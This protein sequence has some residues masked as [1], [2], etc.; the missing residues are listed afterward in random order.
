ME[1]NKVGISVKF[2][3][4]ATRSKVHASKT[5]ARHNICSNKSKDLIDLKM[6]ISNIKTS[7]SG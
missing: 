2:N 5:K 1:E 6:N 3:L 7:T 4:R